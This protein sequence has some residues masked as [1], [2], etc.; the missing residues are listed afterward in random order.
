MG[1]GLGLLASGKADE[2]VEAI[3]R[4]AALFS[5]HIGS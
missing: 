3:D 2:A 4:G 1:K 5:D